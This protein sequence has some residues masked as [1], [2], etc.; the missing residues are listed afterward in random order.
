MD[1]GEGDLAADAGFDSEGQGGDDGDVAR[2]PGENIEVSGGVEP[3]LRAFD[4]W[5][6]DASTLRPSLCPEPQ[7][8]PSP[9]RTRASRSSRQVTDDKLRVVP[10]TSTDGEAQGRPEPIDGRDLRVVPSKAEGRRARDRPSVVERRRRA[11]K[12][13]IVVQRYGAEINGGAELHARYV[14]ER[15]ARH[16]QVE[17][18]TTCATDYVTWRNSLPAGR[19]DGPR[20]HG[21]PFSS[22]PRARSR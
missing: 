22:R 3:D 20:R 1:S 11:V 9:S 16:V 5:T 8:R 14:A 13:A 2:D 12:V 7:S 21:P 10:A 18:L 17:V 15:L 19:R 4:P 6:L